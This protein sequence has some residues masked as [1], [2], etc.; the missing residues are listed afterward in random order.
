MRGEA[1]REANMDEAVAYG[2]GSVHVWGAIFSAGKSPL[3]ILD[4]NGNAEVYRN[5]L[6]NYLLPYG[7]GLFGDNFRDQD[8]NARPHRARLVKNYC[9]Q[10]GILGMEQ[11]ARSPD[12]NPLE[13]IRSD[14]SSELNNMDNPPQNIAEHRVALE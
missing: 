14:M 2:G 11:P 5:I 6:E 1:L 7:R 13:H 12:L 9:A 4:R 8:D 10:Q 3:V